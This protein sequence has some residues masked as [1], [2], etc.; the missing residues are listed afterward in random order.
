VPA[1]SRK[2]RPQRDTDDSP[3]QQL[4]MNIETERYILG[5]VMLDNEKYFEVVSAGL[6]A[7]HF[8]LPA[9]AEVFAAIGS[10]IVDDREANLITVK[11]ELQRG[12]GVERTGGVAYLASLTDG[13]LPRKLEAY[14]RTLV[15]LARRRDFIRSCHSIMQDAYQFADTTDDLISV[16]ADRLLRLQAQN[17][18]NFGELPKNLS[19]HLLKSLIATANSSRKIVGFTTGLE[20]LDIATTGI[21]KGEVFCVGGFS[22]T[23][24]SSLLMQALMAN[25]ALGIKCALFTLEMAKEDMLARMW[26]SVAGVHYQRIRA[27]NSLSSIDID[28]LEMSKK[29]IDELPIYLDDADMEIG[30]LIAR[31]W[32]YVKQKGVELIGVDYLQLLRGFS[33]EKPFDRVTRAAESLRLFAKQSGVPVVEAAQLSKPD[34]KDPNTRPNRFMLKGSGEIEQAAHVIV[35]TYMPVDEKTNR[36]IGKDSLII[37]KQR[38]G[39]MGDIKAAYDPATMMFKHR[40]ASTEQGDLYESPEAKK[41]RLSKPK[42]DKA[43]AAAATAGPTLLPPLDNAAADSE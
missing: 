5:S 36:P 2:P 42:K 25:A 24:K 33:D 17:E 37:A 6:E 38:A 16:M 39:V 41:E 35:L 19:D 1:K 12:G 29:L 10:I 14:C 13:I 28:K 32:A 26:A 34:G 40:D 3:E 8:H 43:K 22:G 18:N 15:D 27:A 11:D 31:A 4:P 21:R 23:G 7:R 9:H 20:E 30:Q